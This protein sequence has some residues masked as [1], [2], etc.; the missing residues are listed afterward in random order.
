MRA[1]SRRSGITFALVAA[2]VMAATA[3]HANPNPPE[4]AS[5]KLNT[6]GLTGYAGLPADVQQVR[7]S[8]GSA[9]VNCS[10]IPDYSIGPWPGNPNVPANKAFLLR[11]PRTPAENTSTRT[12]TPLGPIGSWTNGVAIF[13]ALDA[14]SYDNLNIWH[15]NAIT[16][17]GPSFD[18]CDGHPA[19]DGTYHNH[20]NPSCLYGADST[21]HSAL[22]G[23]AF[24]GYP[25]Y[26][27]YGWRYGNATGGI[28]RIRSSYQLRAITVRETL[29][30]GT[31]LTPSQYGPPVSATYPLG[32]YVEDYVYVPGAGD[33][34]AS[35]GRFAV[36]PDY[37]SGTYAYYVTT[38]PTGAPA[39]PYDIGPTYHGVVASDDISSHGH[40]TISEPV[41]TYA[42]TLGVGPGAGPAGVALAQNAPNPAAGVTGIAFELPAAT[43][44]RLALFDVAGHEVARLLDSARPAGA[45]RVV[46][47]AARLPAGIYWYRLAAGSVHVARPMLI[48]H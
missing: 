41:T 6:T 33:L 40:V 43:H 3:A 21:Q 13:N 25:V 36:T 34:D 2:G 27:P 22:L 45:N 23:F 24:D 16:V 12:S 26:G 28:V 29:P 1:V 18:G 30:D 35:N 32:Y 39:Y 11:F 7:Y 48:V 8:D 47:D 14:R 42:P 37:P 20:E 5:W 10:S 9:Y 31:V 4:L 46:F 17:E 38:D 44:V 15:Q 19:P